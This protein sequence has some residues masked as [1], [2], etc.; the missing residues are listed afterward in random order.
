MT[1]FFYSREDGNRIVDAHD[2]AIS[3]KPDSRIILDSLTELNKF[4][5]DKTDLSA[6]QAAIE[7][8]VCEAAP[9]IELEIEKAMDFLR[10]Y[11]DGLGWA[12]TQGSPNEN[13]FPYYLKFLK[14]QSQKDADDIMK[15]Y[16]IMNRVE[17]HL[18]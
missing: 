1:E 8:F 13:G 17:T 11:N 12:S 10:F 14:P 16:S 5:R 2:E 9:K 6:L 7:Y 4:R 18:Y 3:Y 15:F